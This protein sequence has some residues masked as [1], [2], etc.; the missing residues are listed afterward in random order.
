MNTHFPF[1]HQPQDECDNESPAGMDTERHIV[2]DMASPLI[3]PQQAEGHSE[4]AE[5]G[6]D[7]DISEEH[8]SHGKNK[9]KDASVLLESSLKDPTEGVKEL[10]HM[11]AHP[12]TSGTSVSSCFCGIHCPL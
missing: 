11:G 6:A 4:A 10:E 2:R 9:S 8:Q 3:V 5:V 1:S 12:C 7:Q